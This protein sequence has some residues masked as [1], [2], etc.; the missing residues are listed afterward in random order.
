MILSSWTNDGD[1]TIVHDG[2]R[3]TYVGV[4]PFTRSYVAAMIKAGVVGKVFHTL[5]GYRSDLLA[6]RNR[7][8]IVFDAKD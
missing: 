1:L 2:R 4:S 5:K 3:Y 7:C 6:T 8:I